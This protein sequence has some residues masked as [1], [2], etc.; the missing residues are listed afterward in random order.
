MVPTTPV[1]SKS[2][3]CMVDAATVSDGFAAVAHDRPIKGKSDQAG[4]LAGDRAQGPL[5]HLIRT[6]ELDLHL[7]E[8]ANDFPGVG[9]IEPIVRLFC[10]P[11]I[12]GAH[13]ALCSPARIPTEGRHPRRGSTSQVRCSF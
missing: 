12:A 9:L 3:A 7:L 6:V 4:R 8:R 1:E 13:T 2:V 11:S 10:L 5:A